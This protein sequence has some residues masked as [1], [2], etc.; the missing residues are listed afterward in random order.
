MSRVTKL[1]AFAATRYNFN[2]E[3]VAPTFGLWPN[4]AASS[5]LVCIVLEIVCRNFN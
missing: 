4:D 5:H 3:R 2:G 1:V